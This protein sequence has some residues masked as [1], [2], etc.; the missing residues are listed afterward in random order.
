MKLHIG[1]TEPKKG[2]KILNIQPGD[3]VDFVGPCD[4]LSRFADKSVDQI[5]ASHV[6][7]HLSHR[8]EIHRVLAENHRVL[9]PGGQLMI[10]VPNF[11]LLCQAFTQD[12][13]T[14]EQRF[15]IMVYV[16]GGQVDPYDFHKIGLTEEFL[17]RYLDVAGFTDMERVD[18]FGLFNDA[19]SMK[20]G[21]YYLSLNMTA[22]KSLAL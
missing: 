14:R 10:S 7:E 17:G 2:W 6:Y 21:S 19:S 9:K 12:Q 11:E 3:Q 5:Y 18:E 20:L 13:F 22:T 8:G 1:G 4:D 15:Q 16:F